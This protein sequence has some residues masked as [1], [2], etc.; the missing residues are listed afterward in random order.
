MLVPRRTCLTRS[1]RTLGLLLGMCSG[2]SAIVS[3][4]LSG[5]EQLAPEGSECSALRCGLPATTMASADF[6]RSITERLHSISTRPNDRPLGVRRVTFP[7]HI[8]CIYAEPFRMTSGFESHFPLT[9]PGRRLVCSSHPLG[10]MFS[11][12]FLQIPSR[13]G[14][15]CS[16]TRSS[17][18][19]GL[20]QDFHPTSHFPDHFRYPVIQRQVTT[21]RVMIDAQ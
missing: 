8:R 9:Q 3:A 20:Y 11:Y 14:H 10:R 5:R 15:H 1:I 7:P 13:P 2:I 19:Q 6:C 16:S 17:C 4:S 18:H 12:R 21:L